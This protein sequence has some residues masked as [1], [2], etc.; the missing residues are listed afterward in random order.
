MSIQ[1]ACQDILESSVHLNVHTLHS[2]TIAKDI[3]AVALSCVMW[4]G[5]VEVLQ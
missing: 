4:Q 3:A 2:E 1:N 5:A